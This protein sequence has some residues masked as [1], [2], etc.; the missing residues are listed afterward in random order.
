M[1]EKDITYLCS[2][3][4]QH[5]SDHLQN[6]CAAQ[7]WTV[8]LAR[9]ASPFG[10]GH[11]L[12]KHMNEPTMSLMDMPQRRRWYVRPRR[13]LSR[14]TC[15]TMKVEAQRER[16]PVHLGAMAM[17]LATGEKPDMVAVLCCGRFVHYLFVQKRRSFQLPTFQPE[18]L[19][20]YR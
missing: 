6:P 15:W 16:K 8:P 3:R 20:L 2:C 19:I 4:P 9:Y 7:V 12:R 5:N 18:R 17:A 10:M 14:R 1:L 11:V 13:F